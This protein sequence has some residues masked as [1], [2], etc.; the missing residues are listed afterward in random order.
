[1][2]LTILLVFFILIGLM[3]LHE[4]GHFALAKKFGVEV[5]EFGIGYPPRIFGK[6]FGGTLYSLNLLPFG[7]FVKIHGE[8]GGLEDLRSFSQKPIWQ[9]SLIILGGVISFWIIAAIILS[10]VFTMGVPQAISDEANQGLVNPKVQIVAIS[11]NSPAAQAG[12]KIGDTI[13][14]LK[15]KNEA[16]PKLTINKVK[17]VQ[18]FIR[19]YKGKEITLTIQ[20]GKETLD[21]SLIPRVSPPE[22]EGAMGVALV[23]TVMTSYPWWI[24]PIKGINATIGLTF[25]IV[26]GLF[27]ALVKT[28]Q[29]LPT[30]AQLMG[31]IGIGSLMFQF[32]QLGLSYFLQFVATISV[33]L[34]VFNILPIPAVDGGRLLFL[35]IEKFKGSP[36]NPKFEQKINTIFFALLVFLMI[37]VTIKDIQRLF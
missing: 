30:G 10:I 21:V 9:R 35:G 32:A 2:L 12:L 22:N 6:K 11:P 23:R 1:M 25:L 28:F 17:E 33:Y 4:F 31:P 5:E 37:F 15:I 8:E 19:E 24:A 26:Q 7:A 14:K 20:R 36:L 13:T 16:S 18:E 27:Q 29:G 34:A 3:I